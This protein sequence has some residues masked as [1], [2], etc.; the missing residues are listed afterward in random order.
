MRNRAETDETPG[1]VH[2]ECES[3]SAQKQR[4]RQDLITTGAETSATEQEVAEARQL[5]QIEK[6]TV[7]DHQQE[8]TKL[9]ALLKTMLQQNLTVYQANVAQIKVRNA[10]IPMASMRLFILFVCTCI[11]TYTYTRTQAYTCTCLPHARA[12][13]YIAMHIHMQ[14]PIHMHTCTHAQEHTLTLNY[15][16]APARTHFNIQHVCIIHS[17]IQPNT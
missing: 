8:V 6:N 4:L 1:R 5:L 3:I 13:K 10:S 7:E 11:C 15:P 16:Y 17:E 9:L 2:A 14:Y 12:H